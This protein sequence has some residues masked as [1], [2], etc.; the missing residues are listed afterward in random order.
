MTSRSSRLIVAVLLVVSAAAVRVAA[1]PLGGFSID[2]Y[3]RL[4][5]TADGLRLR[6]VI[7]MAEIP[8][9]QELQ[10]ADANGDAQ[11]SEAERTAYL[12]RKAAEL[13]AGLST[14]VDGK[15]AQ[16]RID[17]SNLTAPSRV[18]S[19]DVGGGTFRI[20]IDLRADMPTG[21]TGPHVVRYED[22]NYPART[23]WKEVVVVA[24]D[25]VR[26]ARSSAPGNDLS[27]ELTSYP[28]N[29]P[30]PPQD[31]SAEFTFEP[32]PAAR[33]PV[34]VWVLLGMIAVGGVGRW[35]RARGFWATNSP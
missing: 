32:G 18:T 8:A 35:R 27:N 13:A 25:E 14:T 34:E 3:S 2:H 4:R 9:Y 33:V 21:T 22:Q 29:V 23:G 30:A 12:R 16:W 11:I 28:A 7:D 15:P 6:Y 10:A 26:L 5:V 20:F 17:H 1:H 19:P 24:D 31:V